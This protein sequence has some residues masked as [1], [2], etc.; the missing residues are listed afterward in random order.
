[1]PDINARESNDRAR[2]SWNANAA[3]WH[4][5]MGEGNDLVDYLIW[6]ATEKLLGLEGNEEVLDIACGNGV[7]SRRL[8]E[9]GASVTA[10]DFSEA[11]IEAA[12]SV[13]S[14]INRRIDYRR[15]DATDSS[16]LLE[17]GTGRFDA[18]LCGMALFDMADVE[19]LF[20]TLPQLLKP[21]GRFVFSITHPCFNHGRTAHFAEMEDREGEITTRYGVKIWGYMTPATSLGVGIPGQP[22]P[23]PYFHRPLH[24]LLGLLFK[25]GFVLDGFE[26]RAFPPEYH[27]GTFPLSWG[28]N[29]S[30]IPPVVVAR[31]RLGNCLSPFAPRK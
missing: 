22:E 8:S 23:H 9:K 30:E 18:A 14:E 31:A 10:F 1:M 4:R 19:P 17:L 15:I 5:R 28:G 16:A 24:V 11:M 20:K 2:K 21:G 3:F 26:E 6:P 27:G 12:A 7:F 25:A 13:E 29:F